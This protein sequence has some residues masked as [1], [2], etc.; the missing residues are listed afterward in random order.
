M[1]KQ[2][3]KRQLPRKGFDRFCLRKTVK[4]DEFLPVENKFPQQGLV[5]NF[6]FK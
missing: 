3:T 2:Q 5:R 4:N 6:F 1:E